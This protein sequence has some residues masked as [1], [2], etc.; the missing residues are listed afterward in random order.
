MARFLNIYTETEM[1]DYE[2]LLEQSIAHL[3]Y[4]LSFPVEN[5]MTAIDQQ[6]YGKAMNHML[7]FFEISIPFVSFVFLRLLQGKSDQNQQIQKILDLI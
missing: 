4:T 7:D 1:I 2:K 3:P 5:A 6:Q